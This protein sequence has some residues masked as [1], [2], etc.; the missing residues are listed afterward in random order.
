MNSN[1]SVDKVIS[2]TH[3]FTSMKF[4]GFSIFLIL[5]LTSTATRA[6]ENPQCRING[7]GEGKC[8]FIN[9]ANEEVSRCVT[10]QL[11]RDERI[12][13]KTTIDTIAGPLLQLDQKCIEATL[14]IVE[15][16]QRNADG[17][18]RLIS[19]RVCSGPMKPG[20]VVERS[21]LGFAVRPVDFCYPWPRGCTLHV[22][23]FTMN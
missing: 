16:M 14:S 10:V 3:S 15:M 5:A 22:E 20:E 8:I 11:E 21:I 9:D 18:K 1:C 13:C 12:D 17:S 6:Q 2:L 7:A 23:E 19:P 4:I